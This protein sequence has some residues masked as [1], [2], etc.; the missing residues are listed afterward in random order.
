MV[1]RIGDAAAAG[2]AAGRDKPVP[3]EHWRLSS[4]LGGPVGATL[5]VAR[6]GA[7]TA[8]AA[9]GRDKPVPYEHWRFSSGSTGP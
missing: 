6:I 7:A 3:Y 9:A 1:A 8:G 5:V 4:G 2:A